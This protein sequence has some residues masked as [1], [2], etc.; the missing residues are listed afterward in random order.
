MGKR[1]IRELYTKVDTG[2]I[3]DWTAHGTLDLIGSIFRKNYILSE[4]I[5][6]VKILQGV[7]KKLNH[8]YMAMGGAGHLPRLIL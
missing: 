2:T 4:N 3:G 1:I 6:Y 7:E 8:G 5:E